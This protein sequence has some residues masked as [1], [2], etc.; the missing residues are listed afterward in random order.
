MAVVAL[1]TPAATLVTAVPMVQ[2]THKHTQN[3]VLAR[4]LVQ[5][6]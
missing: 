6:V 4:V 5:P 3:L 1:R 2:R